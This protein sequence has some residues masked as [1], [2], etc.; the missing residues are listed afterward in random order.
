MYDPR[1]CVKLVLCPSESSPEEGRVEIKMKT[2]QQQRD[3]DLLSL[4]SYHRSPHVGKRKCELPG[5]TKLPEA[6]ARRDQESGGHLWKETIE[7]AY[8]SIKASL[9]LAFSHPHGMVGKNRGVTS[10]R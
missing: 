8:C 10:H 1:Q 3:Q 2:N 6:K 7:L 5:V 9:A 4:G